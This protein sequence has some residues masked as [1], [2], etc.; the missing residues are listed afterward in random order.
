MPSISGSLNVLWRA[1]DCPLK[2][3]ALC[4]HHLVSRA[5][6]VERLFSSLGDIQGKR[7]SRLGVQVVEKLG[8]LRSHYISVLHEEFEKASKM[9]ARAHRTNAHK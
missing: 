4:L 5:A 9:G 2:S 7:R 6:E 1:K 8:H 3:V